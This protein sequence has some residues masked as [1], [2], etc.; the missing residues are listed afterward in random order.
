[1]SD[2]LLCG[3]DQDASLEVRHNV[4]C[5]NF[6]P[7]KEIHL[8]LQYLTL[9]EHKTD[10][11]GLKYATGRKLSLRVQKT[12]KAKIRFRERPGADREAT[13][14]GLA[15]EISGQHVSRKCLSCYG[16]CPDP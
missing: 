13:F 9:A 1:V 15:A 16:P 14:P 5:L 4:A 3:T 2:I 7:F 8:L 12:K 11:A 6:E 10:D